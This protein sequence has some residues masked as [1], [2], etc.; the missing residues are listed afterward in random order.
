LLSSGSESWKWNAHYWGDDTH[1]DVEGVDGFFD[2]YFKIW[3][4]SWKRQVCVIIAT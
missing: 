1:D 4:A 2:L 3:V